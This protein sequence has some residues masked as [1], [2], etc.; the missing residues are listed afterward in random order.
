MQGAGKE[1]MVVVTNPLL[2]ARLRASSADPG[3]STSTAATLPEE[4]RRAGRAGRSSPRALGERARKKRIKDKAERDRGRSWE[5]DDLSHE[6]QTQVGHVGPAPED[7][8]GVETTTTTALAAKRSTSVVLKDADEG[9]WGEGGRE[10]ERTP[11]FLKR[12]S[13][14]KRKSRDLDV[15]S[16]T[17][18][19]SRPLFINSANYIY[20]IIALFL[21]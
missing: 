9:G 20:L 6:L 16:K 13:F 21:I 8:G 18:G 14:E 10:R 2:A 17:S 3:P 11:S 15:R 7:S 12:L 1:A 4:E 5:A 19:T